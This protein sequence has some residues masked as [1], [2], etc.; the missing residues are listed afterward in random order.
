MH[1][2]YF[3]LHIICRFDDFN[4]VYGQSQDLARIQIRRKASAVQLIEAYE[5]DTQRGSFCVAEGENKPFGFLRGNFDT[6]DWSCNISK[7][8]NREFALIC[9]QNS[10]YGVS[11]ACRI[12]PAGQALHINYYNWLIIEGM[13]NPRFHL[14]LGIVMPGKLQTAAIFDV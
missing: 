7:I 14:E 11:P 10:L 2:L 6:P 8:L 1:R 9:Y 3:L 12:N 4:G 13:G 5:P